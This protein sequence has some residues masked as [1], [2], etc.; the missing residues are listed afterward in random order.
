[1]R[2]LIDDILIVFIVNITNIIQINRP[3]H[4][5]LTDLIT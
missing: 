2:M 5:S 4:R 1:M 3:V